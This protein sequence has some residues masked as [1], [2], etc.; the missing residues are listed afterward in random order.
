M[1][2][3]E[4]LK[5]YEAYALDNGKEPSAIKMLLMHYSRL[6]GSKL[7]AHM[8]DDM[9]EASF[10]SFKE[11]AEDYVENHKPVQHLIGSEMFFGYQFFVNEHVLIPRFETEELVEQ[12]L[13]LMDVHFEAYESIDLLDLGT[14]SGCIAIALD[15]EDSRIQATGS[16]ISHEAIVMAK[17]NA[18]YL[19][20]DTKFV[21]GDLFEPFKAKTFDI[22]ISN[23]PYIPENEEMDPLV[24]DYEPHVALFGGNDGLDFYKKIIEALPRHLND[25]YLVG[26]EHAYHHAKAIRTMCET[27]LPNAKIV[28]KKDMQGK[29]R[30]TFLV[31][32]A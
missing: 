20:S 7:L 14:G 27:A 6:T 9:D 22:I 18:D 12:T 10:A 1:T 24:K 3:R 30:M 19:K 25:H 5:T 4:I 21:Q 17:K 8:N 15:L 11:A 31:S 2:Y 28:Q 16:D 13:L 26:F 29:D 32:A 23:P